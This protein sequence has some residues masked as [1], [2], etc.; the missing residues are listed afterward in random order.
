MWP[1]DDLLPPAEVRAQTR[2]SWRDQVILTAT[3]DKLRGRRADF[4]LAVQALEEAVAQAIPAGRIFLLGNV[5]PEPLVG[6]LISGVGIVQGQ[7]A[8]EI[9][10]LVRP[11]G[12]RHLG[13][14]CP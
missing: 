1:P 6:S 4:N 12:P 8:I 13:R 14:L 10:Q 9:W 7:D 5:G 11:H 2:L 3:R